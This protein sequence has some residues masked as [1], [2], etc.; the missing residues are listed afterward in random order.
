MSIMRTLF[1]PYGREI[2]SKNSAAAW[3]GTEKASPC[4]ETVIWGSGI[5]SRQETY[6]AKKQALIKKIRRLPNRHPRSEIQNKYN[7][8]I[9]FKEPEFL[10]AG[11]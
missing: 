9:T 1:Y 4:A 10:F 8:K 7:R 6:S 11:I 5:S 3:P 2:H